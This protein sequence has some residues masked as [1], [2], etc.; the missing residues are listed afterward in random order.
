MVLLWVNMS[1]ANG[2][3]IDLDIPLPINPQELFDDKDIEFIECENSFP[4]YSEPFTTTNIHWNVFKKPTPDGTIGFITNKDILDKCKDF[5]ESTFKINPLTDKQRPGYGYYPI[6][7]VKF[8]Q[9]SAYHREGFA[10]WYTDEHKKL[11]KSR[12]QMA[13]NF[14]MYGDVEGTE[15]RFGEPSNLIVEQEKKLTNKILER[16]RKRVAKGGEQLGTKH[17]SRVSVSN[18]DKTMSVYL[19]RTGFYDKNFE[20]ENIETKV[21][22]QG[23]YSPFIINV[24]QWHKVVTSTKPRVSLRFMCGDKYTFEELEQLHAGGN[25]INA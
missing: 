10:D 18:D 24:Q 23:Y 20:E 17:F 15:V 21:V 8:N 2:C 7:L 9:T 6:T 12:F 1:A 14:K 3:Y 5:F 13:I 11:F 22:R 19:G 16:N 25:L 4:K